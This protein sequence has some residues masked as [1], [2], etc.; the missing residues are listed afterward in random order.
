MPVYLLTFIQNR[1]M[2]GLLAIPFCIVVFL[3]LFG[4]YS[5]LEDALGQ[6]FRN[7]SV[8]QLGSGALY[9]VCSVAL[10]S[11]LVLVVGLRLRESGRFFGSLFKENPL[12]MIVLDTQSG[13]I[14]AHNDIAYAHFKDKLGQL[15]TS[16]I[17]GAYAHF[18]TKS[19][20][21]EDLE[22]IQDC[23]IWKARN[24]AGIESSL[25]IFLS[26]Q[27]FQGKSCLLAVLAD[28]TMEQETSQKLTLYSK[29]VKD[30]QESLNEGCIEIDQEGN[31]TFSNQPFYDI[32]QL[33]S[34]Q[35]SNKSIRILLDKIGDANFSR[36]LMKCLEEGDSC[37]K[38]I[39]LKH[40]DKWVSAYFHPLPEGGF[41]Y[42]RD[43]SVEIRSQQRIA[44]SEQLLTQI[45]HNTDD[46][47]WYTSKDG[48]VEFYNEKYR[49]IK[50]RATGESFQ[51]KIPTGPSAYRNMDTESAQKMYAHFLEAMNTKSPVMFDLDVS[52]S[53]G[54]IEHFEFRY[55]PLLDDTDAFL[56]MCC[57]LRDITDR[58]KA[59]IKLRDNNERL[60]KI[61]WYESHVVRGPVARI[62]GLV[63]LFTH[64]EAHP[65]NREIISHLSITAHELDLAVRS[66]VK[67]ATELR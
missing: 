66:I 31:V 38:T 11:Y 10:L 1:R 54:P 8:T 26:K 25:H 51:G 44:Q 32:M 27:T 64:E 12:P 24:S 35:I 46:A 17:S 57:Y 16:A 62:L 2:A 42:F 55:S 56:G 3:W 61:A 23:G 22:K 41:I 18:L 34:T 15:W 45:I 50:E 47:I 49:K 40:L 65:F 4:T 53:G 58:K 20:L 60:R 5:I 52:F 21:E 7:L 48:Q 59:E 36:I 29:K 63:S 19:A 37:Y 13:G 30:I 14:M 67:E 33:D 9:M 43:I 28:V 6:S 39:H